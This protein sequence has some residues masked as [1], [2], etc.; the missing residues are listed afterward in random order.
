MLHRVDAADRVDQG[1]QERAL[2]RIDHD[3]FDRL[4]GDDSELVCDEMRCG[5][6]RP[7]QRY[8]DCQHSEIR[9]VASVEG[10]FRLYHDYGLLSIRNSGF[11]ANAGAVLTHICLHVILPALK[12]V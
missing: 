4:V 5:A 8:R 7:E 2:D 10:V 6:E 11:Y 9:H 12:M 1:E 3:A